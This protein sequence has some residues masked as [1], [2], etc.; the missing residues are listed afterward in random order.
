MNFIELSQLLFDKQLLAS[1]GAVRDVLNKYELA[2]QHGHEYVGLIKKDKSPITALTSQIYKGTD[3]KLVGVLPI[4]GALVYEETGWEALCG[5]TSY[6]G[7]QNKATYM[8]K[9][10]KIDHLIL[11]L[12]SGG[13]MAYGCF[14]TAQFVKNL[15]KEHGVKITSYVDG[16]AHSGG[17]AW[18]CIADEVILNPMAKVGSI[19]VVLPLVNSSERDKKEGIKRVYVTAGKS[20]VPFDKDGNFTEEALSNIQKDVMVTY[21]M[22]VDHVSENRNLDRDAVIDTEAKTFGTKDALK[23]GLIDKVMTKE[24]FYEHLGNFNGESSMSLTINADG[25]KVEAGTDG[26]NSLVVSQLSTQI[27][28]LES[29][30]SGLVAQ[31]ATLTGERDQAVTDL[32]V[33]QTKISELTTQLATAQTEANTAILT[34]RR[35][36]ISALVA[37]DDVE[38]HMSFIADFDAEKFDKYKAK[39]AVQSEKMSASFTAQGVDT[40]E[41]EGE[42]LS[43]EEK[44]AERVRQRNGKA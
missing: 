31:V 28:T 29:D 1:E 10:K 43:V 9:E 18:A 38:D 12:N 11:E 42:K 3:N 21:D 24:Q 5:M 14:E 30:K 20:K 36:A 15:A 23:I 44:M 19:G 33:A 4:K 32:G 7:L 22:F 16:V 6:E 25:T 35:E 13:G 26:A 37:E 27:Q 8:I 39:L 2:I 41:A 40:G 34:A 17:Y